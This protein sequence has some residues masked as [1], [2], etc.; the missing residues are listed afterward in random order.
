[1]Y[2]PPTESFNGEPLG[3]LIQVYDQGQE[4][5]RQKKPFVNPWN[6]NQYTAGVAGAAGP[7]EWGYYYGNRI[8]SIED[9]L[10][11]WFYN[12]YYDFHHKDYLIKKI[13]PTTDCISAFVPEPAVNI[14]TVTIPELKVKQ[15]AKK[16]AAVKATKLPKVEKE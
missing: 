1:M 4:L 7:D 15:K 14:T 2:R 12:G 13:K 9:D 11:D 16:K 8:T 6:R 5:A 10:C 3:M